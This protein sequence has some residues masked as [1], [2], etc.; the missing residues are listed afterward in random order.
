[1]KT[2]DM[3]RSTRKVG[4]LINEAKTLMVLSP[5]WD[6]TVPR[7]LAY[8]PYTDSTYAVIVSWIEGRPLEG[9]DSRLLRSAAA[10]LQSIHRRGFLHGDVKLANFVVDDKSRVF[11]IDFG[12]SERCDDD[13]AYRREQRQLRAC[14]RRS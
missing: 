13:E 7:L 5:L 8:G 6:V 9:G 14:F 11:C 2:L 10:A 3:S 4:F 12:F 1:V